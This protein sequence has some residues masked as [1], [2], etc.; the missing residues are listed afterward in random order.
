LVRKAELKDIEPVL[1]LIKEFHNESMNAYN[2]L[3]DEKIARAVMGN[4]LDTSFILEI[5][6]KVVGVLGGLITNY[7][8]NNKPI[9]SEWVWYVDPK[10]RLHGVS[11]Y[12]KVEE[13]CKEKGIKQIGMALMANS[14][15]D[16]LEQF[17]FSLGFELLEKHYIKNLGE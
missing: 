4:L 1:L 6:G 12:R 10:Y 11:L 3:C 13:Y 15:A 16:K 9:Y 5:E 17:Y 2:V 14:K 8:L 7:P